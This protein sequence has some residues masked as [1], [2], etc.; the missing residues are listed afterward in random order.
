MSARQ[1]A[2]EAWEA[3]QEAAEAARKRRRTRR[4]TRK[5]T[6]QVRRA[7]RRDKIWGAA[8]TWWS[9]RQDIANDPKAKRK[10]RRVAAAFNPVAAVIAAAALEVDRVV[11][12]TA[13]D[14]IEEKKAVSRAIL[15]EMVDQGRITEAQA[16]ILADQVDDILIGSSPRG[17]STQPRRPPSTT[18]SSPAAMYPTAPVTYWP[19]VA[20]A[21]GALFILRGSQ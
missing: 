12:P 9:L 2:Q 13:L 19:W 1:R 18:T 16:G 8:E 15:Q 20:A 3:A 5:E 14:F 4:G 21:L 10:I 6:R 11:A 17:P 7:V